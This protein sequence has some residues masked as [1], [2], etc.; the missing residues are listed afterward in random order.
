MWRDAYSRS[1][2][3][4]KDVVRHQYIRH[5]LCIEILPLRMGREADDARTFTLPL[6]RKDGIA[7]TLQTGDG[8]ARQ[9][10]NALLYRRHTSIDALKDAQRGIQ[11]NNSQLVWR[12]MLE[13]G[14]PGFE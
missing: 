8:I 3:C 1:S 10:Q 6:R 2:R 14:S 5:L 12:T 7:Q 11:T 13:T 9:P 4:D